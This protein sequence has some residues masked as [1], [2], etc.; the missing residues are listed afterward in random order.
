M[1]RGNFVVGFR[2][3]VLLSSSEK[4]E[5]DEKGVTLGFN[6]LCKDEEGNSLRGKFFAFNFDENIKGGNSSDRK[7]VV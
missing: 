4:R 1:K 7:S 3:S 2:V 6:F 5:K